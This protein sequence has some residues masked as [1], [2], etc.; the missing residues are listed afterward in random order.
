MA[1]KIVFSVIMIAFG[2]GLALPPAGAQEEP[3]DARAATPISEDRDQLSEAESREIEKITGKKGRTWSDV[4]EDWQKVHPVAKSSII[5]VDERYCYPHGFASFKVEIVHEDEDT[6]WVRG[7]PPEDP[8]SPF[9]KLWRQRQISESNYRYM[10]GLT[11]EY[12]S[13]DYYLDFMA[14]LVP[15]PFMDR[16]SFEAKPRGLPE[17]GLWQMNFAYDDMN[18]DGVADLVFPPTRKGEGRPYIYLGRPDGSFTEARAVRWS[19]RVPFDYGGIGTG[20]FDG[21][22][23]RDIVL[24]IHF[25]AQYVLYGDGKAGFERSER[26]PSPDP[27]VTSRAPVVAD[28]NNDGRDDVAC[29][30]ELDYDLGT[31]ERIEG[32]PTVWVVLN[33]DEGWRLEVEGM[34]SGVIG[35]NLA[36]H[37]V[38]GDGRTDLVLASNSANF[39]RLVLFNTEEG[40]KDPLSV[41]VLSNAY[42]YDVAIRESESDA[43]TE[44]FWSFVQFRMIG[45]KNRALTGV[46]PYRLGG[47]GMESPDG[48]IFYDDQ[49]FNPVFRLAAGDLTGDGRTDL[50]IG[51]RKGGLEVFVQTESGDYYL[52]Q[53]PELTGIGRAYDIR[54]VDLNRD[55]YDDVVV[56]FSGVDESPGGVSVYLTRTRS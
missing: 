50:V 17:G 28:F 21:D 34:P 54:L 31:S 36:A 11:E 32:A 33:T 16:L 49:R 51:R 8:N 44:L 48:P 20:D 1:Q 19:K 14:E 10:R 23:H 46:I 4:M 39:R 22:G 37:D 6:V 43:A 29:L 3:S 45:T 25:K 18:E 42:H 27:R 30:A 38:D 24:A 2:L 56:S 35:D 53:S 55:G 9:H 12:G 5:R 47:D 26:L 52:E 13:V 40:W 41:G 7:L 15:P